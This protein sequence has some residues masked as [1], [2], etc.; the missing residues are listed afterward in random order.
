ME[1]TFKRKHKTSLMLGHEMTSRSSDYLQGKR[2]HGDNLLTDLDAGDAAYATNSGRASKTTYLSY[3]SRLFYSY[4]N[5][6]QLTATVRRDGTSRFAKGNQ[7]GTFPSVAVAWRLSEESFWRP[8]KDVVNNFKLRL[9]YGEV[10]NSNVSAFAYQRMGTYVQSIWGTSLQTANIANPDLTWES[11]RSWNAGIDLNFL[12]TVSS[13]FWMHI[14][15]DKKPLV[16]TRLSGIYGNYGQWC[17]NSSMGEY[18][19]HGE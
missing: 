5:R 8:L 18:R 17:C 1:K 19:L 15:K 7:W 2:T 9:S 13:L 16:A 6:Y 11:T 3:F 12:I 4:D 14:S 10:G